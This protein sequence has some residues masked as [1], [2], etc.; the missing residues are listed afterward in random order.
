MRNNV[1]IPLLYSATMLYLNYIHFLLTFFC[2]WLS[3]ITTHEFIFLVFIVSLC[4]CGCVRER[5]RVILCISTL[6]SDIEEIKPLV[7]NCVES[8]FDVI[9][10]TLKIPFVCLILTLTFPLNIFFIRVCECCFCSFF[11]QEN[12]HFYDLNDTYVLLCKK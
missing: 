4:E 5:K 3:Q 12:G 10:L 7:L 2:W 6:N 11:Y 8:I 9:H 1:K